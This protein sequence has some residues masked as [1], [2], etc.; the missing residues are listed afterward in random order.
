VGWRARFRRTGEPLPV[1]V[2]SEHSTTDT[3][4]G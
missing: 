1:W 4:E 3:I 2:E